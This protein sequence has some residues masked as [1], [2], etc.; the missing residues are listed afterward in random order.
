MNMGNFNYPRVNNGIN[1][2]QGLEG[3]KAY[4][5][6][7]NSNVILMDQESDTFYIKTCD[8]VGMCNLRTFKY[9]EEIQKTNDYITRSELEEILRGI[10]NE[11]SISGNAA[12]SDE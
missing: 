9:Q 10:K 11:Q 5:M 3:A 7:P 12:E 4:P 1:W 2:V 8:N 6:M